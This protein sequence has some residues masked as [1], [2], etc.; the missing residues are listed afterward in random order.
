MYTTLSG[1]GKRMAEMQEAGEEVDDHPASSV[2][3]DIG[4]RMNAL[5]F[6]ELQNVDRLRSLEMY[7][8]TELTLPGR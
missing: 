2:V 7:K 8:R 4:I 1:D 5:H 6:P 3:L